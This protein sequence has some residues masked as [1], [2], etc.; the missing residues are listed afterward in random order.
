MTT[1]ERAM[2]YVKLAGKHGFVKVI[3][4]LVSVIDGLKKGASSQEAAR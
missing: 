4:F 1:D 3:R 2:Y